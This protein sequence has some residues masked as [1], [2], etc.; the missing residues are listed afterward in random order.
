[1]TDSLKPNTVLIPR[2]PV[3]YTVHAYETKYIM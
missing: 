1:M 2:F 3:L